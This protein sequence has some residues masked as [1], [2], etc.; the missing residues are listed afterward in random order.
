MTTVIINIYKRGVSVYFASEG[1]I[2]QLSIVKKYF[3]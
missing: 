3:D 2:P 1:S